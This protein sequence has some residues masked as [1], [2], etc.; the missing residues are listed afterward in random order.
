M[1]KGKLFTAE[2][3]D[4]SMWIFSITFGGRNTG[5]LFCFS[6]SLN[7]PTHKCDYYSI[8]TH[9]SKNGLVFLWSYTA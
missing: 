7:H 3:T 2:I 9:P 1:V 5:Y 6:K 4:E 8:T